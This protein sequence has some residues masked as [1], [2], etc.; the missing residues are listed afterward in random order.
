MNNPAEQVPPA[1]PAGAGILFLNSASEVLLALRDDKPTI[2]FPNCWDIPGGHLDPGET[3]EQC[4]IREMQEEIGQRIHNPT[5]FRRYDFP[6]R[7]D[8]IFWSRADFHLPSIKLTEGQRLQWFTRVEIEGMPE[9]AFA[10]G[11]KRIV[12]DFLVEVALR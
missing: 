2:P 7:S 12:M 6:E 5:F 11:F 8:Y 9:K 3:P 1:K 10:F 4:V